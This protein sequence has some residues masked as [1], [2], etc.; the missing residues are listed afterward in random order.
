[1]KPRGLLALI[2]GLLIL[3]PIGQAAAR[4]NGTALISP[5]LGAVDAYL[6]SQMQRHALKGMAAAITQGD[7]V[8]YLQGFG[9]AGIYTRLHNT[10]NGGV[11][12]ETK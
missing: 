4:P 11:V 5:D 9:S 12:S 3:L 6:R 7:E 10:Q 2:I 8:I 1:M